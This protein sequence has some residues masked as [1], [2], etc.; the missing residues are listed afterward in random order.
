MVDFEEEMIAAAEELCFE[1]AAQ[2]RDEIRELRRELRD[3]QTSEAPAAEAS[4][5]EALEEEA[6][7]EARAGEVA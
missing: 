2:L 7:S 1:Y 5:G 4:A 3:V 6:A